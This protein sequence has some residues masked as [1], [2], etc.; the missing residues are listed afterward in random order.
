MRADAEA[1]LREKD[2]PSAIGLLERLSQECS[3]ELQSLHGT[4]TVNLGW[5]FSDLAVAY[6]HNGQ[7]VECLKALAGLGIWMDAGADALIKAL[8]YNR[9]RCSKEID[10]QYAI[11]TGGCTLSIPQAIATVAAPRTLVPSGASAACLALVP[12]HRPP[13]VPDGALVVCP[14]VA[15]VWNRGGR[16]IERKELAV[17]GSVALDNEY[18]CGDLSSIAIGT[19]AGKD[20]VRVRG[21]TGSK[22]LESLDVFYEWNGKLLTPLVDL[23]E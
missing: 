4:A 8:D 7:Y 2:Y 10:A 20:L 1:S 14:V 23:S 15:V 12:G 9:R 5:V 3:P 22:G 16:A 6:E 17:E 19:I 18:L 11:K 21:T 13:N